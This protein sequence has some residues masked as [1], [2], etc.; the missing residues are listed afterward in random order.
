MDKEHDPS[1]EMA[2]LLEQA[3]PPRPIRQGEI[4]EGEVV[5]ANEDG[6]VVSVGLK[7][8]GIVPRE[9]MR[10]ISPEELN[11]L[12]QGDKIFVAVVGNEDLDD[13][14]LLSLDLAQRERTWR[15]LEQLLHNGTEVTA[16]ITGHNRGGLVVDVSGVRGF[17][18]FSH[19][20]PI[21]GGEDKE[22]ALEAR[23][24]EETQFHVLEVDPSQERLVLSERKRRE[25]AQERFLLELEEG[26][27]LTG[28]VTSV[29]GFGAF[30]DVGD[31]T[32]LIP[33]SELS[34]GSVNSPDTVVKVGDEVK[35]YVL[36]VDRENG[37]MTLSLKR[38]L[39]NPWETVNEQ[40]EVSQ[41]I[42][43]TVTR[44]AQFG[45]FVKLEDG[46]E[47]LIHISELSP[48]RVKH[49]K[50]CVYVGQKV[51]VIILNIDAGNH[52]IGLSYKQAFG[53]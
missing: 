33:L 2:Q 8:E 52:R 5:R 41:V 40:Y 12:K 3:L 28:K 36:K 37:R 25:N 42:Q 46:I 1:S 22:Q 31:A 29:R 50:E 11:Q 7:S 18:P 27:V 35:V 13:T 9:E 17:V 16:R 49:P 21:S 47:G 23:V 43:G 20:V 32:G 45:A 19:A 44:L 34:W 15:G 4:V 39:P 6:I 24:G 14:L 38:T 26:T 51:T 53:L 48:R 10:T 30:V